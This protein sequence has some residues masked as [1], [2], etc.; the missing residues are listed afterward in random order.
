MSEENLQDELAQQQPEEQ[1]EQNALQD[2]GEQPAPEGTIDE[3]PDPEE[4]KETIEGLKAKREALKRD[5]DFWKSKREHYRGQVGQPPPQ[6]QQPLQDP[7]GQQRPEALVPP[8]I[9]DFKTVEEFTRAQ[10]A[11]HDKRIDTEVTRRL[12]E[13]DRTAIQREQQQAYQ[14]RI[15]GL[16]EKLNRGAEKYNDFSETVFDVTVP[17]TPIM[18]DILAEMDAPEDVAY[19]LARNRSECAKISRMTPPAAA[20]AMSKIE[21][22]ISNNA[23]K[24]RPK[25]P[26]AT[27]PMTP[28][29]SAE[30]VVKDPE[31]MNSKEFDAWL[32]SRGVPLY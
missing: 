30:T 4:L 29:G 23:P 32:K 8:R 15:Q 26:R 19:Y 27:K 6:P 18:Q 20:R 31:K 11:Y 3:A 16:Y 1:Q 21:I 13:Y 10:A 14:E 28:V 25:V 7:A 5:V 22:D 2:P 17:I 9:E 24:T 12:T